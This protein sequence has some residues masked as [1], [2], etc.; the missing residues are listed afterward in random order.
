VQ[1]ICDRVAILSRGRLIATGDVADVLS[2]GRSSEMLVRAADN[3][4]AHA[5]LEAGGFTARLHAD[6]VIVA[7]APEEAEKV[8]R[9]LIRKRVYPT[10]LRPVMIDLETV[11][12][13][14]TGD[15]D[16]EAAATAA[17]EGA[18]P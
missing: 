14:L 2:A 17:A 5:A 15:A 10:E 3:T 6:A 1:Q 9:A 13:E 7:V 16:A 18:R 8:T 12:L 4:A 11:F